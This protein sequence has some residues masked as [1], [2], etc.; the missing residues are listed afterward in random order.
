MH[1]VNSSADKLHVLLAK[2]AAEGRT[3]AA[4]LMGFPGIRLT[5][6]TVKIAQQNCREHFR[7]IQAL[8]DKFTPD[9]IFPLMD[10]SVE[11]NA[12]GFYTVF[13]ID[14]TPTVL[15]S[16]FTEATIEG[17][18]EIDISYDARIMGYVETVRLL[19]LNLPKE[20]LKGAFV[21]GPFTLAALIMGAENAAMAA[22]VDIDQLHMLCEF[23]TGVIRKYA[24]NLVTAGAEAICLLEPS[25]VILG[26]EQFR[27]FSASYSRQVIVECD[28]CGVSTVYHTCGNTTPLLDEMVN[29]GVTAISLDSPEAGID[30]GRVMN[31]V[32]PSVG[33]MGNINPT[34]VM[35]H[36]AVEKVQGEVSALLDAVGEKP[37]FMLSTGCDLPLETPHENIAAFM[38]TAREYRRGTLKK[39]HK[40]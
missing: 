2:T 38:R 24:R 26:P 22:L 32:P 23:T 28:A 14:D 3:A 4:P 20:V 21:T 39:E 6:S 5:G 27:E 11:A 15:K 13:P 29:S 19:S 30:L 35:L 25:A 10:L 37:N 17:L 34:K 36:G 8:C 12:L 7:A 40:G 33:V 9:I 16:D 31:A 1:T 18:K